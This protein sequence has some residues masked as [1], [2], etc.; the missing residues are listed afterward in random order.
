M[1]TKQTE[2]RAQL[3]RTDGPSRLFDLN[4]EEMLEAW[5]VSH[6]IREVIS[7]ALDEQFLSDTADIEI[8]KEGGA[9]RVRDFGRGLRIEHFTLNENEEKLGAGKGVIGK[10]GV[11]LKDALATFHRRGVDVTIRSRWGTFIT[12]ESE[13]HAFEGIST[14]HISYDDAPLDMQGTEFV[15][16]GATDEAMREAQS[17][18]LRFSDEATL[19]TTRYGD[20]LRRRPETARVYIS[21]VLASEEE[22]F[23]FSYNVTDLTEAC[24]SGLTERG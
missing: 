4:I 16:V 20:I 10:F 3:R 24:V 8:A 9:W 17:M 7:N 14:L 18:F 23:L 6:A 12:V 2:Q 22:N 1:A 19:E 11:G 13:K 15:L 5:E 21:G